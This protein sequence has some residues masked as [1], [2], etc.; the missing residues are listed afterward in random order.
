MTLLFGSTVVVA[1]VGLALGLQR[2]LLFPA[3]GEPWD[4]L[5]QGVQGL[6]RWR[7]GAEARGAVEALYLPPP[8]GSANPAPAL[9]FAHGNGE[10]ADFWAQ[11]FEEVR[12]WGFAVLL[13]E[14]PGYGRS[15]GRPSEAAITE[16]M[17]AAY[18]A[19]LRRPEVDATRIVGHGRSLGGGAICALAQRREL[20]ALVLQ[21]TFT[22]VRPL[23]RRMGLPGFLV[24]DPFDNLA[25]VSAYKR[26]ILLLHGERDTIIPPSHAKNLHAA[27]SDSVLHWLASG[28]ND[29]PP[30]WPWMKTFFE[31]RGILR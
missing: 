24:L 2:R 11:P 12:S 20:A 4:G 26:P 22:G 25:V 27:A 30:P 13:V 10:L 19:L 31:E 8:E 1:L 17:V 18:D 3:P 6:Q 29:S 28:H 23:A 9:I 5:T 14:Y 15:G 21:S 16:I 7:L